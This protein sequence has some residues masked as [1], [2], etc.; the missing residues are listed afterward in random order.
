[1]SSEDRRRFRVPRITLGNARISILVVVFV[2]V[3]VVLSLVGFASAQTIPAGYRGTLLTWGKAEEVILPEGLT[4]ILPF[5]QRIELM[6]VRIN[7]YA[8][9][10][11]AATSELLETSN[12]SHRQL[13]SRSLNGSG[14]L[15]Q[16]WP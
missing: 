2:I 9:T 3:I 6:D 11:S 13:S 4:F 14:R 10:A 5:V 1:M 16:Y 8:A 7:K 15:R 12:A